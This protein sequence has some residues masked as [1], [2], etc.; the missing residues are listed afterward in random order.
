MANGKSPPV[1]AEL[2][3]PTYLPLPKAARK[4]GLS[5]KVLTQLVQAGKIEA[6]RLPS[7]E[8]LVPADNGSKIP[9][10][11]DEI[12]TEKFAHLRGRRI[13]PYAAEK[14]YDGIHRSNFIRWARAG[15]IEILREENRLLEMDA[16]DVAYCA[17]VYSQKKAEYG[18]NVAGVRIFDK[19]GNPYEV[20][21][22]DLSAKRRA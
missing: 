21:Y 10:T 22:P 18:G 3:I 2:N 20:K 16:A 17:Y 8:V 11:K 13:S 14:K 15:Y 4:Y 7:G 19:E 12:I 6:V 1:G 5:E 9:Q